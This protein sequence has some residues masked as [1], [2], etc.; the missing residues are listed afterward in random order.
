MA[1]FSS[2]FFPKLILLIYSSSATGQ[3]HCSAVGVCT[4]F[5]FRSVPN[6]CLPSEKLVFFFP[7]FFA[8]FT[9]YPIGVGVLFLPRGCCY[10]MTSDSF[11]SYLLRDH[12]SAFIE[13][14]DFAQ[15][16]LEITAFVQQATGDKSFPKG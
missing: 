7:F 8:I 4:F 11:L 3:N 9:K 5:P 2:L 13:N 14:D 6:L 15:N 12:L 1:C 16:I 10:H